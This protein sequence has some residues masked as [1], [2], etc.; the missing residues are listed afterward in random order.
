V[1]VPHSQRSAAS[2]L[3]LGLLAATTACSRPERPDAV[4]EVRAQ[5]VAMHGSG[6]D[7]R[8]TL[9]HEAIPEFADRDGEPAAMEAMAMAFG[10]AKDVDAGAF[11]T[12]SKWRV[13]FEVVW[14]REPPL[15][16]T[17]ARPLPASTPL[18]L[19]KAQ[20]H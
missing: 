11:T 17:A 3:L 2:A 16:I 10:I 13:R 7:R 15:R 8:V 14:N 12:G 18:A 9:A 20:P 4:Y 19:P 1:P 6:D 5:V